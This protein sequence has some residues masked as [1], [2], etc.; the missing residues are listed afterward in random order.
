MKLKPLYFPAFTKEADRRRYWILFGVIFCLGLA[1]SGGLI[2]YN[3]PVPIDSPSF[4]PVIQRR[5]TALIAMI[6]VALCQGT[7]TVAFQ[8]LT[9]NRIITP[10]L[11]GF[12]ALYV[13]L[14]TAI[15]FFL[16]VQS[17]V[18]FS[19]LTAFCIQLVLMVSASL[20]LYRWLL[21]GKYADMQIMLLVGMML[22]TGLNSLATF[23]RR[24]LAP[25][26]FDILQARLFA[27]VNHAEAEQFI[28]AVPL[29]LLAIAGLLA[30]SS[31]LDIMSLGTD[32]A[33]NLG[34]N[35]KQIAIIV[36]SLV[37]ILMAISTALIGPLSFF[38]F[39]VA[40]ICYQLV[41]TYDHRYLFLMAIVVAFAVLTGA[42]FFMYHVFNAQ[43]VVG[44]IIEV[45]GGL[46]FLTVLLRNKKGES[47]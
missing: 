19:G 47:L 11:L 14:Q 21:T 28:L 22:G 18:Q 6:I 13:A 36:L 45:F 39:L 30:L 25:S 35:P 10:S 40:N 7:A 42:Y 27:S 15:V 26:E 31:K 23:M 16:G 17:L 4:F 5:L 20:L 3:N 33:K 32:V 1:F 41:P 24:M 46:S 12:E 43:G 8:S 9:Q 44:V 38:G 2:F 37:A 34:L 29:C